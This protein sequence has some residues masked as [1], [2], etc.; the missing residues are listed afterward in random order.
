MRITTFIL[1]SEVR[2]LELKNKIAVVID[3][4]RATT[5]MA[6]AFCAGAKK[7][8]PLSSLPAAFSLAK[9]IGRDKAL[10]CG[11]RGG[12][13]VKGFDLG[14]SPLEFLPET[15]KGKTLL[16]ASTN[17]T[18]TVEAARMARKAF[19]ASFANIDSAAKA[20]AKEKGDAAILCSGRE[21]HFSLEDFA[22]AGMLLFRLERYG[23][24]VQADDAGKCAL[25]LY[26]EVCLNLESLLCHSLHGR[27][28]I[29]LGMEK[30]VV[31]CARVNSFP[32]VPVYKRGFIVKA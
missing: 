18:P 22:C 2:P 23:V 5:T 6:A 32:V 26:H 27:F 9:K 17:G 31:A 10:L 8:Y 1:P 21:G 4:L 7:I 13:K 14:N 30:D 28:L 15:V 19:M 25:T 24:S 16:M 11:E 20:I 29:S 12:K 3:V